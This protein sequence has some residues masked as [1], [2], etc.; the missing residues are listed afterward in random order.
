MELKTHSLSSTNA[1]REPES[2]WERPIRIG[3]V[4]NQGHGFEPF[5][6]QILCPECHHE[7][8]LQVSPIHLELSIDCPRCMHPLSDLI[9]GYIAQR[10]R[11]A[12]EFLTKE[13]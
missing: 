9:T 4:Q 7:F 13:P 1:A 8:L 10:E 11:G 3:E 12:L 2:Q 6:Q 5:D